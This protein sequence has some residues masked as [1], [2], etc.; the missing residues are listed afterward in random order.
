M[1]RGGRVEANCATHGMKEKEGIFSP[2]L[3]FPERGRLKKRGRRWTS[4]RD[5]RACVR[6]D[7]PGKRNALAAK[8]SYFRFT[9]GGLIDQRWEKNLFGESLPSASPWS[10]G[11]L[12]RRHGQECACSAS[13][14]RASWRSG[15]SI[16]YAVTYGKSSIRGTSVH[17]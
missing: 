9:N 15:R 5:G 8:K 12:C 13:T 16:A 17:C 10:I 2:L 11:G 3:R 7:S 4:A 6:R 14:I 1:G